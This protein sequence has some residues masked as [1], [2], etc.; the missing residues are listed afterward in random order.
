MIRVGE[1]VRILNTNPDVPKLF[2]G[3]PGIGK[4][5]VIGEW[6]RSCGR[7]L[8]TIVLSHLDIDD[9]KGIPYV[10]G[11][12]FRVQRGSLIPGE[13]EEAVVFLDEITT[14]SQAKLAVALKI[15]D[16][17]KCGYFS[18]EKSW[19]VVAGNPPEWRGLALDER[20]TSR[21]LVFEVEPSVEDFIDYVMSRY[22][23]DGLESVVAFLMFDKSML[24][25]KPSVVGSAF[26]TP[27][28]WEKVLKCWVEDEDLRARLVEASVGAGVGAQ[29]M[30]FIKLR[31][32]LPKV[33]EILSGRVERCVIKE[34]NVAYLLT[35]A[36]GLAIKDDKQLDNGVR[37]IENSISTFGKDLMLLFFKILIKRGFNVR[38][39]LSLVKDFVWEVM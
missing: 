23:G 15:L 16:E 5:Q 14:A 13:G 17:R 20:V 37:F 32:Q 24:L 33:S 28:S 35:V 7:K 9:L 27:R 29:F 19:V 3:P 6:A 4:T 38:K 12:E 8:Y 31:N 18:F 2:I 39:Y 10:V 25:T 36:V 1:M 22:S 26:A 30:N 21:C 34:L 11:G